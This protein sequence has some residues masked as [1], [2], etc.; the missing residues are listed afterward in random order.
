MHRSIC[1][2]LV[3]LGREHGKL[4][5]AEGIETLAE[6]ELLGGMGVDLF[7]GYLFGRPAPVP[8]LPCPV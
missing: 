3:H 4:V 5:L 8:A 1:A 6:K 2:A 7:Q